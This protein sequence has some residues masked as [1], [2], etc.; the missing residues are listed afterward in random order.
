MGHRSSKLS[1]GLTNGNTSINKSSTTDT[2]SSAKLSKHSTRR[3]SSRFPKSRSVNSDCNKNYRNSIASLTSNSTNVATVYGG[4]KFLPILQLDSG[5]SVTEDS[6]LTSVSNNTPGQIIIKI[7]FKTHSQ[8]E[9]DNAQ[10]ST[11]PS[12]S[13]TST[14]TEARIENYRRLV[15]TNSNKVLHIDAEKVEITRSSDNSSL[16]NNNNSRASLPVHLNPLR[17][18][19][20]L[21]E[22]SADGGVDP[23]EY[24]EVTE[25]ASAASIRNRPDSSRRQR[26]KSAFMNFRSML[27]SS[28]CSIS[29]SHSNKIS[30][31]NNNNNNN[32]SSTN[33]SHSI[34]QSLPVLSVA[35]T[36]QQQIR[37]FDGET[38]GLSN[39]SASSIYHSTPICNPTPAS[40][41]DAITSTPISITTS[42]ATLPPQT[43]ATN[44]LAI[45]ASNK[46]VIIS[47]INLVVCPST[48]G[49]VTL[50]RLTATEL[51]A[52]NNDGS[53]SIVNCSADQLSLV[54]RENLNSAAHTSLPKS[55]IHVAPR[56][57]CPI[58]H[59]Q[60]D[61]V[62]YLVPDL[63][64]IFNSS[65]YWGK[66]DRY[67]AERLLEGKPE[68]TFLLRDSAQEEYLFSVTFRKYGRSLHA[69]IEQSGHKFSFDCHD[70]AVFSTS[71]VTGLL[72][73]Y[74]D[75][76]SVMFFEPM[77][78]VPFHRG[79][80]FSLQQLARAAIVS[81]NT[82]DGIAK[83]E[84][85]ARLKAYL[86]EYHY[87][88]KL[89]VKL[90]D[91]T[92]LTCT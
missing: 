48:A 42:T 5:D 23:V 12:T 40:A 18:T 52:G 56:A 79:T 47:S 90:L 66:M 9:M 82:Y 67:E 57:L 39:A 73:H 35:P 27:E 17:I 74:K 87:K 85:P 91:E 80:V 51:V 28:S 34:P 86:K 32:N 69:R 14:Q 3:H 49:G 53:G 61:F 11:L 75:P 31:G 63:E 46:D 60:V 88:Q 8:C 43:S 37:P 70:P 50:E 54:E 26:A 59:S 41:S 33:H 6:G 2:T 25:E 16:N 36:H 22:Q 15:D 68:G 30:N 77:L 19:E 78:T 29:K 13:H 89:R 76:G 4:N 7:R 38:T 20:P 24:Y 62:H 45:W 55:S 58:V 64:R 84:L 92:L 72:E 65:F 1:A 44:Q 21:P 81:H 71:T 10:Q 83:L